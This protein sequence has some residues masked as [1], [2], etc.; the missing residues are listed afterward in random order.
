M[1]LISLSHV[2]SVWSVL[3]LQVAESEHPPLTLGYLYLFKRDDSP[4]GL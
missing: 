3:C 1:R 4:A 2:S